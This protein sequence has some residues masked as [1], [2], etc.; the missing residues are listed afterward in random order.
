M[1]ATAMNARSA[2]SCVISRMPPSG[3]ADSDRRYEVRAEEGPSS[4]WTLSW[5]RESRANSS[6]KPRNSLLAGK[7]QLEHVH[8]GGQGIKASTRGEGGP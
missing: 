7:I 5:R 6:L 8:V 3:M 1:R 2:R 4:Q